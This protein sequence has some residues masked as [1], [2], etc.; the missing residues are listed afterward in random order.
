MKQ[1]SHQSYPIKEIF[2]KHHCDKA[3]R[4]PY[5]LVYEPDLK[6]YRNRK[7]FRLLEVGILKGESLSAWLEY[8]PKASQI[9]AIDTFERVPANKVPV[10]QNE[11]VVYY[12]A[13][14]TNPKTWS[15]EFLNEKPFDC[16]IDDGLHT[17][18]A[19]AKTFT[20]LKRFLKKGGTYYIEDIWQLDIL[21]EEQWKDKWLQ[22]NKKIY[23]LENHAILLDSLS[24]FNVEKIDMRH[25]SGTPDSCIYKITHKNP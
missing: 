4:H 2:D 24:E 16:I 22:R 14:S 15:E 10:L 1:A 9:T 21:T 23:T 19:N 13:D 3:S 11:R 5:H 7:T 12:K 6:K 8:F 18:I 17:P 25:I 20:G